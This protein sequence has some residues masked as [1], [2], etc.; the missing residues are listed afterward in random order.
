MSAKK[1]APAKAK[2]AIKSNGHS[3]HSAQH[4]H[5]TTGTSMSNA[6]IT[7]Q[8]VTALAP[9]DL[10][11]YRDGIRKMQAISDN[12]G[13]NTIAGYHGVPGHFCYHHKSLFLPWHRAYLYHFEQ[14]LR[15]RVAG[16]G[17]PWWNWT[18]HSAHS[19]G[20]PAAFAA[21]KDDEGNANPLLKFH[22]NVPN[23]K[24]PLVGDT[25]RAPQ[26]PSGLPTDA[27]VKDALSRTDFL[28]FSMA[29]ENIHDNVHG[30]TGGWMGLIPT[31]AFDPIFFSHHCMIDRIW[32]LW[33]IQ[34]G[35]NNIPSSMLDRV[36]NPF[37][38]KVSDV[39]DISHLG[40]Q[41]AVAQI[42]GHGG[43]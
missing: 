21:A 3:T 4:V 8:E 40:Y 42:S 36:L 2:Q 32:Y 15:D 6:S 10:K 38:M 27:D 30:W 19:K 26:D 9:A 23:S 43:S 5:T 18:S 24:P 12:R 7:R 28:D 1:K 35:Q 14:Y 16:T 22:A 31:A 13:F 33:Q 20:I 25:D 41:Y 29:V 34:N 11:K 17:I 39:L 37:N